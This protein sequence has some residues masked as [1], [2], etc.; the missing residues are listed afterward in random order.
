MMRRMQAYSWITLPQDK[1]LMKVMVA[2]I[3]PFF[4]EEERIDVENIVNDDDNDDD[5]VDDDIF[6]A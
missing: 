4:D 5:D 2:E 1:T 6:N 3:T